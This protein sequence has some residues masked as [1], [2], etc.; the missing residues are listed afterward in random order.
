MTKREI[1][2][3]LL[4]ICDHVSRAASEARGKTTSAEALLFLVAFEI[5]KLAGEITPEDA[6]AA[7]TRG[8]PARFSE[9]EES[10]VAK[11]L[12]ELRDAGERGLSLNHVR[13]K[14]LGGHV[15]SPYVSRLLNKMVR[16]GLVT[17]TTIRGV[18]RPKILIK[19]AKP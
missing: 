13:R 14:T 3:R 4:T 2:E 12:A 1:R 7:E 5:G 19:L 17:A 10:D 8:L 15:L 11:I 6:P 18:G 16:S 9:S